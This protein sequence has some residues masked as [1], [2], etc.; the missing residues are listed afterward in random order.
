MNQFDYDSPKWPHGKKTTATSS[1]IQTLHNRASF[2]WRFSSSN[3]NFFYRNEFIEKSIIK[4]NLQMKL[5]A[6]DGLLILVL[7]LLQFGTLFD[8]LSDDSGVSLGGIHWI[9]EFN[10][11]SGNAVEHGSDI[12]AVLLLSLLLFLLTVGTV[13]MESVIC[14]EFVGGSSS[15]K[16]SPVCDV[17]NDELAFMLNIVSKIRPTLQ[18]IKK[19]KYFD[20][21]YINQLNAPSLTIAE[22]LC[23]SSSSVSCCCSSSRW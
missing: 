7:P 10:S 11:L 23:S 22:L 16:S 13:D 2:N 1:S 12:H 20:F 6:V 19:I 21:V 5:T 18:K 15:T 8:W 17:E 4:W 14:I 3:D 9:F